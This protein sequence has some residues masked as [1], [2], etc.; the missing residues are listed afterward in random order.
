MATPTLSPCARQVQRYD[1][2]RFLCDL[3]APPAEREGLAALHAFNLEVARIREAVREP[4][5]G[6]IRL[7]WW[8]ETLDAI[9]DGR[10]PRH[11]VAG[12]LGTTVQ[13]YGIAREHFD[14]IL[15]GRA[16]DLEDRAPATLDELIDYADRTSASLALAGLDV[17]GPDGED[18]RAA[19]REVGIAWALTGLVRAIPFH[20]RARR[21]YLP[22]DL[23]RE[24]G[25]DVYQLFDRGRTRGVARVVEHVV[26][27]AEEH[28]RR[29]RSRRPAVPPRALP[30]LLPATLA[31]IYIG[32]LR[33]ARWDPFDER[34]NAPSPLR[35]LR[36]SLARLRRRY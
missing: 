27:V 12:A 30:I 13:R 31:E 24:A 34:I 35:L 8:G 22:T 1:N 6:Q 29:A 32:R 18:T 19:V 23:N 4:L 36:L 5:L 21:I 15:S 25:L 17:V 28:L 33:R 26:G 9:Y 14:R 7:R 3:F 2:D 16:F 20:A 10:P 11:D